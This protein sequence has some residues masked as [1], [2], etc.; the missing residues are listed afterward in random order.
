MR[1]ST[2]ANHNKGQKL[3]NTNI[4][5]ASEFINDNLQL[6]NNFSRVLYP[7]SLYITCRLFGSYSSI[8]EQL[9]N[10]IR[11]KNHDKKAY[12]L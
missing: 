9:A 8:N 1:S 7:K 5:R 2:L 11:D 10:K 12:F 4:L 3:V 6:A